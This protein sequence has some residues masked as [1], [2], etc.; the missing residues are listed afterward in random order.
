MLEFLVSAVK[1]EE[2]D[3]LLWHIRGIGSPLRM[4][5]IFSKMEV[6]NEK[7]GL[8][9]KITVYNHVGVSF[10]LVYNLTKNSYLINTRF[11]T[12]SRKIK[13]DGKL[14]RLIKESITSLVPIIESLGYDMGTLDEFRIS[15]RG[16]NW[17]MESTP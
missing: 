4:V 6:V 14:F 7:D 5:T 10:V 9:A 15:M 11:E 13:K 16:S 2:L 17:G 8:K 1:T 12:I 3:D